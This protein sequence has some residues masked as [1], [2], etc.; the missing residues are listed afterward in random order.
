MRVSDESLDKISDLE[1]QL[2]ELGA[3]INAGNHVPPKTRVVQFSQN[4]IKEDID[5]KKEVFDRLR[6]ENQDLVERLGQVESGIGIPDDTKVVP[7]ESY[8]NLVREK[9]E[10]V[11]AV[12]DKEKRLLRL[13]QV[14]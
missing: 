2:F 12:A 13:K 7:R 5:L 10:M 11:K 14:R 3:T 4:P 9:N 1:Q 8:A 6:Q